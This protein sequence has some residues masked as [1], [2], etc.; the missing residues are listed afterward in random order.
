ME[1]FFE[2]KPIVYLSK[3]VDLVVLNV[4]FLISCIP[5]VTIGAAFCAL[6]YTCVKV[7]RRDCGKLFQEYKR[8]FCMNFKTATISW[9]IL[10]VAAGILGGGIYY[11]LIS[12]SGNSMA[13]FIGG[14]MAL[15][16]FLIAVALYV[17]P[18]LSRF[19]AGSR[20]LMKSAAVMSVK[21]SGN[22][23]FM[24]VV[25]LG[26][27]TIVVLG[28]KFFPLIL[29]LG[30]SIYMLIISLIM[31]PVLVQYVTEPEEEE[32]V[33]PEEMLY[34]E[35]HKRKPWYLES[36]GDDQIWEDSAQKGKIAEKG[37][38]VAHE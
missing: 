4:I 28:W 34:Q 37:E 16:L 2:S 11:L 23:L 36:A 26:F 9:L 30:P 1:R 8:S 17:F 29:L 25:T 12:G 24:L 27:M 21:H 22:T 7:V 19:Q 31:E 38:D 6:Y 10:L 5:I 15:M 13:V 35:E 20:D 14:C 33:A 32:N 18:V 3:F